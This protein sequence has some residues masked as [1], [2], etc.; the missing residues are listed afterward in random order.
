M[1]AKGWIILGFIGIVIGVLTPALMTFQAM[2]VMQSTPFSRDRQSLGYFALLGA[3]SQIFFWG[4]IIS[5]IFG[6][7]KYYKE[8]V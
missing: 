5:V 8:K 6:F 3:I 4:G 2:D 1:K 7:I